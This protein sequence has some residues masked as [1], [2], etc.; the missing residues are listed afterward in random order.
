[1]RRTKEMKK[2]LKR[3]LAIALSAAMVVGI[4]PMAPGSADEF[5]TGQQ[6]EI[7]VW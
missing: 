1:M 2:G 5:F 3:G 6:C 4:A 7:G